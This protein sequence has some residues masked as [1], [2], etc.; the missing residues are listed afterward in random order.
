MSN[1]D[2]CVN[3]AYQDEEAAEDT[4]GTTSW[5]EIYTK[6][7]NMKAGDYIVIISAIVYN[8]L[9]YVGSNYRVQMDDSI[10][11]LPDTQIGMI[12]V[13]EK[14]PI[15]QIMKVNIASD[16]NHTFDFDIKSSGGGEVAKISNKRIAC[17]MVSI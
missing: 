2:E 7:F 15:C 1:N 8:D 11:I 9:G 14:T 16:G 12:N 6:T 3:L 17:I 4:N 5:V 10:D 13:G